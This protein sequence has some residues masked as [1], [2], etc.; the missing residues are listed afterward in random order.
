LSRVCVMLLLC[1][2][3]WAGAQGLET[4][5]IAAMRAADRILVD[6]T[7]LSQR[8]GWSVS[9]FDGSITV[10]TGTGILTVF[11][12]SPDA[13]WQRA[14]DVEP[15][16]VPL[17]MPPRETDAGWFVPE[18]MLQ[19]LDIEVVNEAVSVPGGLAPLSF[20]PTATVGDGF[21]VARLGS[22]MIALR[23]FGSGTAGSDTVSLLLSDLALLALVVPEQRDVLDRL[24]VDGPLANDHPLLVT[25]TA[26]APADWEP[27]FVFEQ[28]DIRFE[29]RYPFR[30]QVVSGSFERVTPDAP[31]VGVV[32]LPAR[33]S[34][35][36]PMTVRWSGVTAEVTFRPGR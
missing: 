36:R 13:L 10:R 6:L 1:S 20:P 12:D 3:G 17:S 31:A 2:F 11:A 26:V 27:A 22:G 4:E 15:A 18:D 24:L 7:A 21:E 14:G 5:P 16:T 8:Y 35:D 32:L 25:V 33:F 28:G 30:V 23:F 9:V 29:V 34:L 19:V